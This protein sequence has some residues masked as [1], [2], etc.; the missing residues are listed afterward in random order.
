MTWFLD[1]PY[2]CINMPTYCHQYFFLSLLE[3]CWKTA[4]ELTRLL[5]LWSRSCSLVSLS[6]T[7]SMLFLITPTTSWTWRNINFIKS[8][9]NGKFHLFLC[10]FKLIIVHFDILIQMFPNDTNVRLSQTEWLIWT[11]SYLYLLYN[12]CFPTCVIF[13]LYITHYTLHITQ[14]R[15][16]PVLTNNFT[17]KDFQ[18]W[19]D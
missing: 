4:L 14:Q 9:L 11:N 19:V 13:N 8:H 16:N 6:R 12:N 17:E 15:I 1:S 2:K 10:V 18:H 7:L 3:D 5:A